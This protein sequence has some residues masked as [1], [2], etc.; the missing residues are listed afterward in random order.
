VC[1]YV[2]LNSTHFKKEWDERKDMYFLGINQNE[3]EVKFYSLII[4]R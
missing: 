2:A 4:D 3:L 1:P